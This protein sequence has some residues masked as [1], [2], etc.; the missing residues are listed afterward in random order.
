[1]RRGIGLISMHMLHLLHRLRS[2][3][4]LCP[5]SMLASWLALEVLLRSFAAL[6]SRRALSAAG[7]TA[8]TLVEAELDLA[9]EVLGLAFGLISR[10]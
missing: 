5:V 9:E 4:V 8:T 7:T 10:P 3:S 2:P 6:G 1:M